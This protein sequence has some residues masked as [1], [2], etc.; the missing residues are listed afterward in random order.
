MSVQKSRYW[1]VAFTFVFALLLGGPMFASVTTTDTGTGISSQM[2]EVI[3]R[4]EMTA[5]PPVTRSYTDLLALQPG[6]VFSPSSMQRLFSSPGM[7][8][9]KG[10]VDE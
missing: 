4:K 5:V 10:W 6:V 2:G 3:Q 8:L 1:M 9:A 7:W